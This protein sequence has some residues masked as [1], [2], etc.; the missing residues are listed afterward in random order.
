M[1]AEDNGADLEMMNAA[2]LIVKAQYIK[3]F[4]FEMP[5][6]PAIFEK[7]DTEPDIEVQINVQP[8]ELGDNNYEVLI[9]EAKASIRDEIAFIVELEYAGLFELDSSV[10]GEYVGSIVLVECPRMLFPFARNIIA[11]ATKESGMPPLM[12]QPIDF[13]AIVAAQMTQGSGNA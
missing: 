6:A 12:L 10:P 8:D 2:P 5:G 1:A 4:S 11:S 9:I 7:L 3:D 13:N